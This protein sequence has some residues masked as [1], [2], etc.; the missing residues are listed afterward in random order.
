[1]VGMRCLRVLL[2]GF[3]I[4]GMTTVMVSAGD[5]DDD[6]S[7]Y[8]DDSIKEYDDLGK[9]DTN[10]SFIVSD[11][12]GDAKVWEYAAKKEDMAKGNEKAKKD[13]E[14]EKKKS[15][16]NNINLNDGSGDNNQ[17]SIVVESGST[18]DKVINIVI[19]K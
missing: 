17:N 7:K 1:M 10:I 11:A 12:L 2:I 9:P 3:L 14:K 6:I 8:K 18:V 19:E 13:V 16:K 4:T 15:N 5:F